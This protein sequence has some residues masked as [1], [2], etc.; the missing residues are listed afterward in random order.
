MDNSNP[1]LYHCGTINQAFKNYPMKTLIY[2]LEVSPILGWA[3]EKY[4][5]NILSIEH[6]YFLLSFAYKWL[7]E[8]QIHVVALP[9]F[10]LYKKDPW[11]DLEL[12]KE[13]HKV[14]GQAECVV[15]HNMDRFDQRKSNARMIAHGL[16]CPSFPRSIDTLKIARR[17]FAFTSNKLGDLAEFLKVPLPKMH[18]DP[19]QWIKA[20][21]G[22]LKT[23]AHIKKYNKRDITVTEEVF[24]KL[25]TY[26][27]VLPIEIDGDMKCTNP[28]CMSYSYQKRGYRLTQTGRY[29][30][31]Q[32]NDCGRWFQGTEALENSIIK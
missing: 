31:Y 23:W 22:D 29:Q 5:T 12:A 17:N 3:Y 18:V 14:L 9:D 8:K 27:K 11:N 16:T 25:Q 2:D 30:A 6:D 1:S 19:D 21:K 7:G 10:P 28:H 13:L 26:A 20:I 4:D 32:C 15:G 24:K